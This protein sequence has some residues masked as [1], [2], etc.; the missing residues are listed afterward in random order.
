MIGHLTA[1]KKA[2]EE[3]SVEEQEQQEKQMKAAH[4]CLSACI[5]CVSEL[6][7]RDLSDVLLII[8]G[9]ELISFS[10][11]ALKAHSICLMHTLFIFSNSSPI[12]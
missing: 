10:A 6:L 1:P 12:R 2:E 11:A 3:L 7:E 4:D 9:S 8:P 5:G